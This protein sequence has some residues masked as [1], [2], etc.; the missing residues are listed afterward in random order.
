MVNSLSGEGLVE[1]LRQKEFNVVVDK[2]FDGAIARSSNGEEEPSSGGLS[3]VF[4]INIR[5]TVNALRLSIVE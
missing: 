3:I 5:G 4:S 1:E 2:D